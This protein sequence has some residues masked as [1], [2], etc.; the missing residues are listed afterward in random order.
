MNKKLSE[1]DMYDMFDDHLI[2]CGAIIFTQGDYEEGFQ[3]WLCDQY[4]A[5]RIV[6][7]EESNV[8]RLK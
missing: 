7:D 8:Y 3:S 1:K 4:D 2:K 6:F 5:D